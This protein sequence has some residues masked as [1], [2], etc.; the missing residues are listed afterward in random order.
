MVDSLGCTQGF[1]SRCRAQFWCLSS[2]EPGVLQQQAATFWGWH[3]V[4]LGFGSY[5]SWS[6]ND[7]RHYPL[8][9]LAAGDSEFWHTIDRFSPAEMSIARESC[10]ATALAQEMTF[11]ILDALHIWIVHYSSMSQQMPP[12]DLARIFGYRQLQRFQAL[13]KTDD[14]LIS[15][16]IIVRTFK[17]CYYCPSCIEIWTYDLTRYR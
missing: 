10:K 8:P 6:E 4:L 15:I 14:Q 1:L 2:P 16:G 7:Q 3:Q 11:G 5:G 9:F 12:E 13:K 17:F